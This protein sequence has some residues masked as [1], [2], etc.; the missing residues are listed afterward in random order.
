MKNWDDSE[1]DGREPS[2]PRR[3]RDLPFPYNQ[4]LSGVLLRVGL[5]RR[6]AW[7]RSRLANDPVTASLLAA[8]MRLLDQHFGP[9]AER[10][11]TSTSL[12]LGPLSQRCVDEAFRGNP[13]PFDRHG[14]GAGLLR[15][16]WKKHSNFVIDLI[17]FAVWKWNYH[18][19]FRKQRTATTRRLVHGRNGHDFV[20]AVHDIAYRHTAESVELPSVRLG[21]AL[22]TAADGD[23]ETARITAGIYTGYLGSWKELYA[24]VLTERGLRLRPGLTLDDLANALS[25]ATDGVTLRAIGDPASGVLDDAQ[26]RSLMGTVALAVVHSFLEPQ[27]EASG[28]TLE[29]AV[30]ARF[31]G[32]RPKLTPEQ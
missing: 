18:P 10:P 5:D 15:D 23:E 6:T 19:E 25:A 1:D 30:A 22:M 4:D 12:L 20:R 27:D 3:K 17:N 32:R 21:L 7:G 29:Q 28:L 31:G 26:R 24:A 14:D 16:R 9:G 13:G 11:M 2:T 8:G